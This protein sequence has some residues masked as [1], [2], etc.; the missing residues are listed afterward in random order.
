MNNLCISCWMSALAQRT[1]PPPC[2]H[3][4]P[5][6]PSLSRSHA[7]RKGLQRLLLPPSPIT[8]LTKKFRSRSSKSG[9]LDGLQALSGVDG[10]G[11]FVLT[12]VGGSGANGGADDAHDAAA[13]GDGEVSIAGSDALGDDDGSEGSRVSFDGT[14]VASSDPRGAAPAEDGTG[15]PKRATKLARGLSHV[16]RRL[17]QRS[18]GASEA[19]TLGRASLMREDSGSGTARWGDGPASPG[20]RTRYTHVYRQQYCPLYLSTQ[21]FVFYTEE[22][23]KM[24]ILCRLTWASSF[25]CKIKMTDQSTTLVLPRVE[26]MEEVYRTLATVQH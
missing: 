13:V 26:Y 4:P 6:P 10:K 24:K 22:K 8:S 11:E 9:S 19:M 25:C 15:K 20:Q 2:R 14:A 12:P 21:D 5:M 16:A 23:K 1:T 7:A 3:R 18:M 17:K